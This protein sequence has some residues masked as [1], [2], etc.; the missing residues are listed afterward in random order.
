MF[1]YIC[2]NKDNT[3]IMIGIY[4]ITNTKNNKVYIGKSSDI[5]RRWKEHIRHSKDEFTKE[6]P[7]IHR[8]INKYGVDSFIFQIIEEC[9]EESLNDREVFY[10][11]LYD[12]RNKEKGYN[13]T[14]GGDGGPVMYGSS[15]P[16]SVVNE[17]DVMY[18][19]E[20]YKNGVYKM[21]C[22]N[23]LLKKKPLNINT[24][25][26]IWFGRS[27]KSIMPEVFTE[28]NRLAHKRLALEKRTPKHCNKVKNFVFDIRTLQKQG[29]KYSEVR[30]MYNFINVNTFNDIWCNR[31]FEY[32]QA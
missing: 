32:I 31:T 1:S 22:Y 26:S 8:A 29:R 15:N 16:N 21:D 4:K 28:E 24:F 7:P 3:V 2:I 11:N 17:E 10:I 30:D 14:M 18:I 9:D 20:C 6:K 5:E 27:Y 19:R 12:S 25:N 23:C 13:I